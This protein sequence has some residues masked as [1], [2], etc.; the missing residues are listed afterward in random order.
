MNNFKLENHYVQLFI[1][2]SLPVL[3]ISIISRS[4]PVISAVY[5]VL[6]L[7]L[8]IYMWLAVVN[9][10]WA[11]QKLTILILVFTYP[12][13]CILTSLWSLEPW[14]SM[15]R[16]LYQLILY[17][18][19]FS[20]VYLYNKILPEKGID[21][22]LPANI[23]VVLISLISIVFNTPVNSW[24]GGNGLGFMGF[25]GHQNTLASALLF[26]LPGLSAWGPDKSGFPPCRS[27]RQVRSNIEQ[28]DKRKGASGSHSWSFSHS[29]VENKKK[30]LFFL[31]LAFNFLLI[32][33]TYSRSVI[34]ALIVF[35]VLWLVLNRKKR[36][37]IIAGLLLIVVLTFAMFNK[38][39]ED[40]I[41]KL[42]AKHPSSLLATRNIL[43]EPSFE[44]SKLGGLSGLGYG[45][46]APEIKT[47]LKTGSH[48]E[49]GRYIR[50]KGNSVLAMIE[51]TGIAGLLLFLL[52]VLLVIREFKIQNSKFKINS[53]FLILNST[54]TAMF[55]H[56]QFE[57]WWVGVGSIQ[58]PLYLLFLFT[59]IYYFNSGTS[60]A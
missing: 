7:L 33:L 36:I 60:N 44:A 58:F 54:L 50:E 47:P 22:L 35:G 45:V 38:T 39:F 14:V 59:S 19:I 3:I 37:L 23:L 11:E 49:D 26:T 43:W 21:F 52:P 12:T 13:Y 53:T 32:I 6:P 27:I 1:K 15:Q 46:S 31:L 24:T 40:K 41:Y 55:V 30:F 56:A 4:F 8:L 48:Y 42:A 28:S 20:A 10:K 5:F 17:S 51:E 16:S 25:A 57:G 34:L 18:G 9:I 29:L 2:Y